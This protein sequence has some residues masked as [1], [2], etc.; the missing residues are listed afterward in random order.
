M[1]IKF[2]A[3][4]FF[5]M[6]RNQTNFLNSQSF[7]RPSHALSEKEKEAI[8]ILKTTTS[9]DEKYCRNNPSYPIHTVYEQCT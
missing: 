1:H 6:Y 8:I 7:R 5:M 2:T 3:Q 4:C 9:K